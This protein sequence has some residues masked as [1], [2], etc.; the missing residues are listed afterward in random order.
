M[1]LAPSGSVF[2]ACP[3]PGVRC[4]GCKVGPPCGSRTRP[5]PGVDGNRSRGVPKGQPAGNTQVSCFAAS[6]IWSSM[7]PL[8]F[9]QKEEKRRAQQELSGSRVV[10]SLGSLE[11]A[12]ALPFQ[13]NPKVTGAGWVGLG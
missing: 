5:V 13:P 9:A 12:L 2:R 3:L 6:R 11:L 1:A 8:E 7:S 10:S 4:C